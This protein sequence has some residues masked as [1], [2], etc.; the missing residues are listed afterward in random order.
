MSIVWGWRIAVAH[1]KE[2]FILKVRDQ[3]AVN[4]DIIKDEH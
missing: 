2:A 3:T 1:K 4:N